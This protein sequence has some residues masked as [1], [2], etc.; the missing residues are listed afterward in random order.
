MELRVSKRITGLI[1]WLSG[2]S[3]AI[4]MVV[5]APSAIAAAAPDPAAIGV[6]GDPGCLPRPSDGAPGEP[7]RE[8]LR[9][10][11]KR[12]IDEMMDVPLPKP[13][14][15]IEADEAAPDFPQMATSNAF[16][17]LWARCGLTRRERSLIT[18]GILMALRANEELKYH[19]RIARANGVT[20]RQIAEAIYQASGYAG[21]PAAQNARSVYR[22]VLKEDS[23]EK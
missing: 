17:G 10:A 3:A 19:F 11:G 8:A 13:G 14:D 7:S 22:Q 4:L 23:A 18:L 2:A 16:E 6:H 12:V 21:F 20:P 15:P 5:T 1:I 9:A